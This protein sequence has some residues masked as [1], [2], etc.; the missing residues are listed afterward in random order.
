MAE[1]DGS[2]NDTDNDSSPLTRLPP[3]E[4]K[5]ISAEK[6]PS[7]QRAVRPQCRARQA[8]QGARQPS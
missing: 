5:H 6:R 3:P 8:G 4:Y 1:K 7:T 2:N